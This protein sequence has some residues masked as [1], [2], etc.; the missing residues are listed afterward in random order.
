MEK[1]L[2]DYRAQID[3]PIGF[4]DELTEEELGGF[5]FVGQEDKG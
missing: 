1:T 4:M 2:I 3:E 5:D